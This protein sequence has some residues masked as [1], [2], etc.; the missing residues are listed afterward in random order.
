MSILTKIK[1]AAVKAA[2]K[3][4]DGVA[5]ASQLS[6]K[7]IDDI[8][9]KRNAYLSEMPSMDDEHAEE[10]I[11]RSM[12]A[13][14]IEVFQAYLPQIQELY[15]PY[16]DNKEKFS[17][18]DR[19]RYFDVTKW[20]IDKEESSTD[21]LMNVYQVLSGAECN[22]ALIF[23]KTVDKCAVIMA[24]SNTSDEND[25][26]VANS[27]YDR[28]QN[29]IKGNF[30]GSVTGK[31]NSDLP[32]C[33]DEYDSYSEYFVSSVSNMPSEK[34][35]KFISQGIEKLLDGIAL[36]NEEEYTIVLLAEPI[37]AQIEERKAR[38][39]ELY[40]AL[41]PYSEW[42]KNYTYT[43]SD[44]EGSQANL[45]TY[46]GAN[47]GTQ[48][49][50]NESKSK[51][52][53]HSESNTKSESDND[54][55]T[56]TSSSSSGF[57]LFLSWSSSSSDTSTSSHSSS[58]AKT[59]SDATTNAEAHGSNSGISIGGNFGLNFA[60][61][62]NITM[63]AGKNEGITNSFTNYG[64]KNTLKII[65]EQIKRIEQSSALG[66]W[67]FAAY[68]ISNNRVIAENTANMYMSLTQGEK[69]FM[70][71]S[72]INVWDT[73]QSQI[74]MKSLKKLR[75]PIFGLNQGEAW[76]M[77][78]TLVNAAT[79]I[80]GKE[81]AY[82]L[83]FPKKSVSGLP[84]LE[85]V[86]FGREV[87]RYTDAGPDKPI[88]LGKIYHM[89]NTE[90]IPVALDI[91]SLAMHT[92]ITGSTGS[93]K[94]NTIYH[95][96][97]ELKKSGVKFL[98]I[99]PAKGEYKNVFG[100]RKDVRVLGTNAKY[101]EL[102]KINP[103]SFPD[104]V[105]VLEHIDRLVEIFNVCWPMYAAMPAILKDAVERAYLSAGWDLG[106][107]TCKHSVGQKK[108]YPCFVDV[109]E[110]IVRVVNESGYSDENKSNYIGA[111]C[112]RVK[113]LTNGLYSRIFTPDEIESSDLF[114]KNTVVD[115]SRIGSTETKALIM[116]LL[117]LKMQEYRMS[118]KTE[119]NAELRHVTVLEEA[120]TLLKRTSTEQSSETANLLGKSVEML[121]NSIAEMRTYGEGFIIAD[122]SPGLLDMSVIRNT[123]T[124]IIL[125]LPDMSDR[126]LVGRAASLND[127]QITELSKLQ[128][129][130]AAVYQNDWLEPV[131]CKVTEFDEKTAPYA[132]SPD[133]EQDIELNRKK[134]L[135]DYV[136]LPAGER[137]EISVDDID[138][139]KQAVFKMNISSD[140]KKDI[141]KY[142]SKDNTDNISV[143]RGRIIYGI[144]N[145]ETALSLSNAERS[146]IYS[147]ENMMLDKLVPDISG[148]DTEIIN[149]ILG[150]LVYENV[151]RNNSA[152][153][154]E[155]C[156]NFAAY[157]NNKDRSDNLV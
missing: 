46:A 153:S 117:V 121:A 68:I 156:N 100:G 97:N 63:A 67:D 45:G 148:M 14:G 19:I 98:V 111:L 141:L 91:N 77:Y 10:I 60:R 127:N 11:K 44:M 128:T 108:L 5:Y 105:H 89:R 3:A 34:S 145:S 8:D 70:T 54:S 157:H 122:Q 113:S 58:K 94:S 39:Y 118:Q 132:P 76:Y 85:S 6:P 75:H 56:N 71:T 95:M 61:S 48:Q 42:Q 4:A 78:P 149:K 112:T 143:L 126:V 73:D 106:E 49:G 40:T 137:P 144:F 88:Y 155:L 104:D 51:G 62:S 23:H 26:A 136:M 130:V 139:I 57:N 41:A 37:T 107:S 152:E 87:H 7:Q 50:K 125:R 18:Y 120:H 150:M 123:N 131:L 30:P 27:F 15:L 151:K 52:G 25:G 86:S 99:E 21:K 146:D 65:E 90:N 66:M 133:S 35:E 20:V 32:P 47:I 69:S 38:L 103:F 33:F 109:L 12:G 80:S 96:L 116:G 53:Q 59:I 101:A 147:W 82:A 84:V 36:E 135:I 22:I 2:K 138:E 43:E 1:S 72:A 79:G 114:D 93:G 115:L 83:N 17:T 102:L 24:V 81:L 64:I 154:T 124:K 13:I 28:L 92:F 29:A 31:I 140:V 119:N 110:Q 9:R 129:G 16:Y 55:N 134:Q 74:I 142:I